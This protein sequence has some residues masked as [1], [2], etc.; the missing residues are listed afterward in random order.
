MNFVM[1][2]SCGKDSTLALHKML[3]EDHRCVGL[4]VMVNE[5]ADRVFFHGADMDMLQRYSEALEL[6][7][8]A[9]SSCGAEYHLA[10]EEGIR[11][12]KSMGAEAV[13]FGDIDL[14]ANRAWGEERCR[15]AGLP[16]VYPLWQ[17]S[18]RENVYE[19]VELGY[20]CLIK[21]INQT[22]LPKD[23]LGRCIDLEAIGIMEERGID[24]CG[25]NGEYHTLLIDGPVFRNPLQF[26]VVEVLELGD[27]ALIDVR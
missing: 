20:R 3:E 6:P 24:I 8:I 27:F 7:L 1:S 4:L 11:R 16:A 23:L 5:E 21:T 14:D 25:E 17:R 12:A 19:L 26:E 18:R 9:C 22:L 10:F 2:Y 15:N 13:C